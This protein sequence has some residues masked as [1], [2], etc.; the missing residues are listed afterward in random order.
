MEKIQKRALRILYNDFSSDHES[1]LNKSGKSTMEVKDLRTLALQV[2]NTANSVNPEYMKETFHKTAF[3][4]HS[5]AF[6][7]SALSPHENNIQKI[8]LNIF[9]EL[10]AFQENIQTIEV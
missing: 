9:V 4:T 5:T 6:S 3:S 7:T 10:E 2:F 8:K 1:I